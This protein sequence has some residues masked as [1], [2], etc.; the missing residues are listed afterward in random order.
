MKLIDM[1]ISKIRHNKKSLK[2]SIFDKINGIGKKTKLIL[3]SYF[4][5]LDN[6]KTA[7]IDDLKKFQKLD[8]NC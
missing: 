7:G 1:Y 5:S 4:G 3:L 2:Q 6:I 8:Q